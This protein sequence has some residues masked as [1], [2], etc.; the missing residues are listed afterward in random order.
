MIGLPAAARSGS[1]ALTTELAP[2]PDPPTL[3]ARAR[4]LQGHVDAIQITENPGL[5]PLGSPLLAATLLQQAGIETVLHLN[6]RDRNRAA[7]QGELLGAAAAG[8]RALLLTRTVALRTGRIAR[9]HAVFDIGVREL[10]RNASRIRDTETPAAYSL[11]KAP[12]FFI[13]AA[14]TVFEAT[15]GWEPKALL[16]KLDA[17]AQWMQTQ[18]CMDLA[19]LRGY[20]RHFVTEHLTHRCHVMVSVTPLPSVEI[21]RRLRRNLRR[22]RIPR[23]LVHRIQQAADPE[24][25]GVEICAE[26]L[27]ELAGIPGVSGA[28]ILAPGE[29]D[30][31]RAVVEASGLRKPAA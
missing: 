31:I 29:P 22:A 8:I 19:L 21:A 9:K 4:R 6:C 26:I 25:A 2:V 28:H 15:A 13:G 27:R 20:M 30:L 3:L 11:A 16:S 17:G 5:R 18:L 23:D 10:I 12:E 1:F 14:A 24:R 7:L